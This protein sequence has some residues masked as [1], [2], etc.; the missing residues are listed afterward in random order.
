MLEGLA[1]INRTLMDQVV[2][3]RQHHHRGVHPAHLNQEP[4][5]D[6]VRDALVVENVA[7]QQQHIAAVVGHSVHHRSQSLGRLGMAAG[8]AQVGI[9]CMYQA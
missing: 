5:Q 4:R 7:H 6:I 9:R 1:V 8:V 3:P 2:V